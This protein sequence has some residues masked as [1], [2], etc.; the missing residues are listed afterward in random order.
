MVS[1]VVLVLLDCLHCIPNLSAY[2]V[3]SNFDFASAK[4]IFSLA[5]WN[6][7]ISDFAE[8]KFYL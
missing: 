8:L 2:F 5:F 1:G 4:V 7:L 6:L 3:Y